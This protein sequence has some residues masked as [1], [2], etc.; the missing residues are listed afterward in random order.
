MLAE[1]LR[2]TVAKRDDIVRR[3]E[4][5][6]TRPESVS[7]VWIHY[8]PSPAGKP[9]VGAVDGSMNYKEY[10]GFAVYAVAAE[11]AIFTSEAVDLIRLCDVD[12]LEPYFRPRDRIRLYMSIYELK[13][14]ARAVKRCDRLLLDGSLLSNIIR[15]VVWYPR[16]IPQELV[17]QLAAEAASCLEGELVSRRYRSLLDD[18]PGDAATLLEYVEYLALLRR[19]LDDGGETIVAVAKSSKSTTYF[20]DYVKPDIAIFEKYARGPGFSKPRIETI[21]EN[22]KARKWKYPIYEGYFKALRITTFYARLVDGGPVLKF[23][24]PG[25]LGEKDVRRLLDEICYFCVSG[26]PY[27]LRK[28][29]VDV[30]IKNV[31]MENVIRV[32]SLY[33]EKTGRESLENI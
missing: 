22:S 11:A 25:V 15:P 6:S 18:D 14:A 4:G 19:L 13:A 5:A 28:V 27:P 21:S 20:K 26:Y 29:H 17:V 23:E 8:E 3:I 1:L 7:K 16:N 9:V 32:L 12:I 10:K 2:V 30:D 24:V 33:G 31:Y